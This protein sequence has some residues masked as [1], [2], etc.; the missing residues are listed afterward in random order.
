MITVYPLLDDAKSAALAFDFDCTGSYLCFEGREGK[1]GEWVVGPWL[2]AVLSLARFFFLVRFCLSAGS[3]V[4]FLK[5]VRVM[6]ESLR[7][8][9]QSGSAHGT[10]YCHTTT[11]MHDMSTQVP[12]P[13]PVVVYVFVW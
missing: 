4:Y 7:P 6:G 8:L 1:E 10:V 13:R 11:A 3:V 5:K 2:R 9:P 12:S